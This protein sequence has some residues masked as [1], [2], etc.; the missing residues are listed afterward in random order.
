MTGEKRILQSETL[1]TRGV[2]WVTLNTLTQSLLGL[3]APVNEDT[4]LYKMKQSFT[5]G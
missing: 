2:G 1:C 3:D 4:Y 5:T